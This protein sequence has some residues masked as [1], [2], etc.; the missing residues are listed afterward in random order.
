M[1]NFLK[2]LSESASDAR[3]FASKLMESGIHSV[4]EV[5]KDTKIYG[6][7]S[8]SSVE[9]LGVDETHYVLVPLL[10]GLQEY[11]IYSKRILPPDTGAINSLPKSRI[12]HVYD[13]SGKERLENELIASLVGKELR[14]DKGSSDLADA[15]EKLA[16]QIDSETN[17][18]SG[19]LVLIG[20]AVAMIN[21]LLGVSIAAKSL[22]PSIGTKASK[23][24]AEYVGGKLRK[25]N[26][27]SEVSKL[28]KKVKK[29][30]SKLK[31]R[32]YFNSILRSLEEIKG[33]PKTDF[34][35]VC[36]RRNWVDTFESL[37]LYE[38]TQEAIREVYPE[39]LASEKMSDYQAAHL[40]WIK[41]LMQSTEDE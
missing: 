25:W 28:Q 41:S 29:D 30:V 26:K 9:H 23:I 3:S 10:G 4:S 37:H 17:K 27:S 32:V 6:A 34:D 35:P 31:P 33:N 8:T 22:L 12:F 21:P 16:D 1:N 38:V 18:I 40:S 36:D 2:N 19:G 15:L 7:L 13:D 20:G 24:G 14:D 39:V 11:A 5:F